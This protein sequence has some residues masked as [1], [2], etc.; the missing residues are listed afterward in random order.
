MRLQGL[1]KRLMKDG[2]FFKDYS[3]FMEGLFQMGYAERSPNVSD[4]N[5]WYIPHHGVYHQAKPGKTT[6]VFDC[7][8]E[9]LGYALSKQ[10]IPGPDLTNQIIGV[11]TRFRKEQVAFMGDIEALFYQVQIPE[12]RRSMLRLFW[13][14]YCNF[15]NQPSDQRMYVYVFG[16]VSSPSRCNYAFERT[17]INNAVQFGPEA[18]KALMRNYYVD[19]LLTSAPDAQSAISLIKAVTK[20][21]KTGGFKLGKF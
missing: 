6:L 4:G 15:S 7:S 10:L 16:G 18:A 13:R 21:C 3:N 1:K 8:A 5:K 17:S 20:M 9:Y 11:L 14:E 12:C 19:D 2:N